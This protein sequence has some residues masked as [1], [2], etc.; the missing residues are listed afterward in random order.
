MTSVIS[1]LVLF[2]LS[3]CTL[4]IRLKTES[5]R[6]IFTIPD[7]FELF[8]SFYG[9]YLQYQRLSDAADTDVNAGVTRLLCASLSFHSRV[10][11][12]RKMANLA[13]FTAM[14]RVN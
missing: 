11:T 4:A 1:G 8:V 7:C 9:A 2:V 6:F 10:K 5:V 3:H 12:R 13:K 14:Q